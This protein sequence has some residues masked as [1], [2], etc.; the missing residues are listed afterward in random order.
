MH[1]EV[2]GFVDFD[3]K[4]LGRTIDGIEVLATID[5]I[6]DVIRI[7]KINDVIFSSDRLTNA[8]ILETIILAQRSGVNF[9][10]VP[11]ELEYI[12]AKSSVDEIDTVQMLD[13]T[14]VADPLD[15]IVKRVFDTIC[16]LLLI[17]VTL[18]L[19]FINVV[20][21]G[22]L[23]KRQVTGYMG[24]PITINTFKGGIPFLQYIPLYYSVFTG[25]LSIVGSEISEYNPQDYR[26][27][28]KPGLTGLVQIKAREKKKSLTQQEK[29]YYNLYYVKNQS[30]ITDIQILLKSIF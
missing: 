8:Q 9:R 5:N 7:E 3:Q 25:T 19:I 13:F 2:C 29:D 15:L 20:V 4:S 24:K 14:G 1:Y 27:I 12:V 17:I 10:I 22:R 21:G 30:V 28:Y 11:H 16:A 6:R 18:P 23:A 26:A